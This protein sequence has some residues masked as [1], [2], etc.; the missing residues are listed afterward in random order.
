MI[1]FSLLFFTPG[2]CLKYPLHLVP[3]TEVATSVRACTYPSAVAALLQAA[4]PLGKNT[5]SFSCKRKNKP[6]LYILFHCLK[7]TSTETCM[8]LGA[9]FM[10]I[11]TYV[12]LQIKLTGKKRKDIKRKT[13]SHF[14]QG[15]GSM[16]LN[17]CLLTIY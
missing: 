17:Y 6:K 7:I 1:R 14:Y 16:N 12:V 8:S 5:E 13:S 3:Y 9:F 10:E 11:P 15:K 2:N 4:Q